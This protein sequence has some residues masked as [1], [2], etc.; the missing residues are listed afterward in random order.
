MMGNRQICTLLLLCAIG[1]SQA[2]SYRPMFA[3][4]EEVDVHV[5]ASQFE[6]PYRRNGELFS[7]PALH[8]FEGK[9]G[10]D[11]GGGDPVKLNVTVPSSVKRNVT[12]YYSHVFLCKKGIAPNPWAPSNQQKGKDG[13]HSLAP[14]LPPFSLPPFSP[15]SHPPIPSCFLAL[16]FFLRHVCSVVLLASISLDAERDACAHCVHTTL[17]QIVHTRSDHRNTSRSTLTIMW[18]A[19]LTALTHRA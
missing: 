3:E 6:D 13:L 5:Y 11:I 4:G 2:A 10:W 15:P 19:V 12:D 17:L 18:S 14:L 16:P 1:A 9:F 8:I 7:S